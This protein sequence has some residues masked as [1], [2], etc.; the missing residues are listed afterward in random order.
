MSGTI[1]IRDQLAD[2]KKQIEQR[3]MV[4]AR[5][6]P[7]GII[8]PARFEQSII[9]LCGRNVDLL[10]K[11]SR[12]S[13]IGAVL[14]AAHLGLDVDPALGQAYVIPFRG[15]AQ[16]IPGYRGLVQLAWRSDVL[17]KIGAEAVRSGDDFDWEDGTSAFLRHKRIAAESAPIT[18]AWAMFRVKGASAEDSTFRVVPFDELEKIRLAAPSARARSSPW[19]THYSEMAMKTAT[20]RTLK[21]APSNGERSIPL[22]KALDLDE[23]A[24]LGL[25]Q[26]NTEEMLDEANTKQEE[27]A[28][29]T[30]ETEV[31]GR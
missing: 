17:S 18:H 26:F 9:T 22:H 15:E 31:E 30:E 28:N 13:L 16:F 6:L 19:I 21:L 10:V 20:R 11:C 2:L 4:I 1:A 7:P 24:D 3:Q 12:A 23:R 27:P 8:S 14:R 5:S 25:T 29:E